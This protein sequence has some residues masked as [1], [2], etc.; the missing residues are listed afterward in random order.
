MRAQLADQGHPLSLGQRKVYERNVYVV[1]QVDLSHTSRR[2]GLRNHLEVRGLIQHQSQR[3]TKSVVSAQHKDAFSRHAFL[4]YAS[5]KDG[6]VAI[7]VP[8]LL[9]RRQEMVCIF[10][11]LVPTD[12]QAL[13]PLYSLC[14]LSFR[15]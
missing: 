13:G 2:V 7:I 4:H 9:T 15:E 11:H 8:Y 12:T 1:V 5:N 6:K 3:F 14:S 10:P